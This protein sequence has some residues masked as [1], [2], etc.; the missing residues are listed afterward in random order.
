MYAIL[1]DKKLEVY[2]PEQE[3]PISH[4]TSEIAF[5]TF[6]FVS[7]SEIVIADVQGKLTFV[8]SIEDESNTTITLINTKVARFRDM[9]C[10][11]GSDVLVAVSTDG[12]ICFY[13]VSELRKF[14][15][16]IGSAKT[17]RQIKSKSSRFLCLEINHLRPE[18]KKEIFKKTKAIKK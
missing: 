3:E 10:H 6:D 14:H 8:K 9:K 16:E 12:K 5:N 1:Y 11:P 7:E 18:E 17:V 2:K 15:L 4:V 13:Q